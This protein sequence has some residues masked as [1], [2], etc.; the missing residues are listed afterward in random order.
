MSGI[1]D[2]GGPASRTDALGGRSVVAGGIFSGLAT[3][4]GL[5]R[6]ARS[7]EARGVDGLRGGPYE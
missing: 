5:V 6:G 2:G 3:V 1:G 7:V 4:A